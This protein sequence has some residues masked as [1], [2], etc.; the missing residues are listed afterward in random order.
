[1]LKVSSLLNASWV[2]Y[3]DGEGVA[4]SPIQN[5]QLGLSTF[6]KVGVPCEAL[7][8]NSSPL[9]TLVWLVQ[10]SKVAEF[11]GKKKASYKFHFSHEDLPPYLIYFIAGLR[12]TSHLLF[13]NFGFEASPFSFSFNKC[14]PSR[15]FC[16]SSEGR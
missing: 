12:F 10:Q 6:T 1:M 8:S 5:L 13:L 2:L 15:K 14:S 16:R 9:A 11:M 4:I 7:L 3:I